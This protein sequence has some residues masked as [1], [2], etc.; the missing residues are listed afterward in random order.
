MHFRVLGT[1]DVLGPAGRADVA[2]P[3]QRVVLAM[4]LLEAG[5]IVSVDRLI[6]AV[7]NESPPSTAKGQIQ[8]CI[9]GLR[10]S[11]ADIGLPGVI[12]TRPPGYMLVAGP[13]EVDLLV[14]Q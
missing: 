12:V 1:L 7:W 11:L 8:I 6:E 9:S 5:R 10:R 2:A 4:L 3:R 14:F 13:D